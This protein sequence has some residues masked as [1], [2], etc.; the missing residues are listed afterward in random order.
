MSH[1]IKVPAGI[2]VTI[3]DLEGVPAKRKSLG[4]FQGVFERQMKVLEADIKIADPNGNGTE[5]HCNE[6]MLDILEDSRIK[7]K[8]SFDKWNL[9]LN[10]LLEEDTDEANVEEYRGKWTNMSKKNTEAKS[11]LV[12]TFTNIKKPTG[13]ATLQ[14]E[15]VEAH[16]GAFRPINELKPFTLE[17]SSTP[18]Q[19][20]EWK[21][22]FES[23]FLS[24]NLGKAPVQVQQSYF[25]SCVS[26]QLANLLDSQISENLTVF[27]DP[28]TPEDTSSC[29]TLLQAELEKRCP[30][31]LRRLALFSTKQGNMSFSDY[32]ALVKK[33]SETADT[34]SFTTDNI[35]SYIVLSGCDESDIL[36]EIL[37]TS[38]NP[39]F[40][41]I[42]RVGTNLEVSRAIL[43][44]LPGVQEGQA[45]LPNRTFKLTGRHKKKQEKEEKRC[46]RCGSFQHRSKNCSIDDDVKCYKCNRLGHLSYICPEQESEQDSEQESEQESEQDSK[47]EQEQE[48]E[49]EEEELQEV[50]DDESDSTSSSEDSED[51]RTNRDD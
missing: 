12:K 17:K 27:P 19:F 13:L 25:R 2:E 18:G 11:L 38:R 24:S 51:Q 23:F 48:E 46:M 41:E 43:H 14:N 40:E 26:S 47:P 49:E 45:S 21:R 42:V 50:E 8:T 7:L 39:E 36:E 35:L 31:T 34:S 37:K 44:A 29:M 28:D 20:N 32:I 5:V 1:T 33:K 30:L 10:Q 4:Q 22:R 16:N 3:P 9:R 15:R 6:P